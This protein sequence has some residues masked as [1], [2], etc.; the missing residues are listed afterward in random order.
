MVGL[1]TTSGRRD[2]PGLQFLDDRMRADALEHV[3]R[4]GVRIKSVQACKASLSVGAMLA[5]ALSTFLSFRQWTLGDTYYLPLDEVDLFA[6]AFSLVSP[7]L[8]ASFG[9]FT[10]RHGFRVAPRFAHHGGIHSNAHFSLV[11]PPLQCNPGDEFFI[12]LAPQLFFAERW[13]GWRCFSALPGA[14]SLFG[15]LLR[16][17]GKAIVHE[18]VPVRV[19]TG[20]VAVHRAYFAP[21]LI[22]PGIRASSHAQA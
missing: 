6:P 7:L 13:R 4:V 3:V 14:A 20:P 1:M 15:F 17:S 11:C 8:P 2:G 19:F 9:I 21:A 10:A 12:S 5:A 22:Y 16:G 18:E